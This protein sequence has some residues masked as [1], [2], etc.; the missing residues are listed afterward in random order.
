MKVYQKTKRFVSS[1]LH[2]LSRNRSFEL[3][4]SLGKIAG[5]LEACADALPRIK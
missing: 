2:E 5:Y 4:Y 1:L 3:G